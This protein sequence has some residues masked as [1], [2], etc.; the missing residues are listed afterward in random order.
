MHHITA[1]FIFDGYQFLPKNSALCLDENFQVLEV[2][3]QNELIDV[4]H[5]SGLLMPG[6]INTH[7]HLELSHLKDAI[8]EQTGLVNFLLQIPALRQQYAPSQIQDAM[9]TAEQQMLQNGIVAVGDICNSMDSLDIKKQNRLQFHSFV[10]CFGLA[11]SQA[12]QRFEQAN[13]LQQAFREF[14]SSSIVMHAPYSVSPTLSA[15]ISS[16]SKNTIS[17][18]HNQESHD[19]NEWFMQETGELQ[20]LFDVFRHLSFE[21]NTTGKGSIHSY[22]KYLQTCQH[23]ILVHNTFTT[24]EDIDF[25]HSKHPHV[26]W[27]LCPNA[28]QYIENT[29]P[30]IPL[31]LHA[32]CVITLGTDSLAS[33]HQLS[34]ISEIQTIH[35]SYPEIPLSEMLQWAT[36][37]GAKALNM[38]A[39]LGSFEIGKKPGLIL[40]ENMTNQQFLPDQ[41]F[42]RRI[43]L[44]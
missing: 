24:R 6:M 40:I 38:S 23:L 17:S 32:N 26:F 22:M 35:H 2:V 27:C 21:W 7:C 3:P 8:P 25:A 10:E 39:Q 30:N 42:I 14:H 13:L 18:I 4:I 1:D 11:P 16:V 19:E 20:K 31:L 36:I 15:L 9:Q 5:Y 41:P 33:N 37:N 43:D 44:I 29:L 34:L 28:N 12:L